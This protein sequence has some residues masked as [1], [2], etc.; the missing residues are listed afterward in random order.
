MK[1]AKFFTK[2]RQHTRMTQAELARALGYDNPQFISNIERG[3]SVLPN[4]KVRTFCGLTGASVLAYTRLKLE[5]SRREIR[6]EIFS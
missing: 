6:A 1:E 5:M 2:A 3:L 4:N